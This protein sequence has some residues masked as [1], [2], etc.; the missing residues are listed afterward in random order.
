MSG[1]L[2]SFLN[3][4]LLVVKI[5]NVTLAYCQSISFNQ[6]MNLVPVGG[7]GAFSYH[8]LEPVQFAAG[9][10]MRV[11]RWT[12]EEWN[13][14]G[15]KAVP[16]NLSE[17]SG[18]VV[19]K[20]FTSGNGLVDRNHF[21]P[22]NLLLSATFDIDV[23][24]RESSSSEALTAKPLYKLKDCRLTNYSFSFQPGALLYEDMS[25]V[26]LQIEENDSDAIAPL[27]ATSTSAG[28]ADSTT[29]NATT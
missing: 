23:Y 1:K 17:T 12:T 10:N 2:A 29:Q 21:N 14:I 15:S 18:G 22:V 11:V 28:A 7:L 25:F 24:G 8:A 9:G 4:S 3:G 20:D 16:E 27:P 13:E 19:S 5:N 26:C 6:N